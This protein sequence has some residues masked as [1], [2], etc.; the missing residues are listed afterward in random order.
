[1]P[2]IEAQA[3]GRVII[4]SNIPPMNWVSGRDA[5][6]LNNPLDIDEYRK[7]IREVIYNQNLRERT[8]ISGLKN[9]KRFSLETVV[10][11]FVRLYKGI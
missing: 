7:M 4:T 6:F 11:N 2:I 9:V 5:I 1:M 10:T 8:I 3:I